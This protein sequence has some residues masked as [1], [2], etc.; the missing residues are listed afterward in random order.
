MIKED[1]EIVLTNGRPSR[2]HRVTQSTLL[3]QALH[4]G[5]FLGDG[6]C[7]CADLIMYVSDHAFFP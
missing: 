1:E 2:M 6:C 7:R 5:H 4:I 3:H